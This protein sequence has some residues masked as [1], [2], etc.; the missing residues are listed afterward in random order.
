MLLDALSP[1]AMLPSPCLLKETFATDY[2][3][4]VGFYSMIHELASIQSSRQ[5]SYTNQEIC[6]DQSEQ[7]QESYTG[8]SL[9]G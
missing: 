4:L 3:D 6:T 1:P 7:E 8:Y 2:T 9:I 5:R